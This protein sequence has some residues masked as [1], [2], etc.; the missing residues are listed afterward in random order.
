MLVTLGM[1][2]R[3]LNFIFFHFHSMT[4]T[5]Y[6]SKSQPLILT[7]TA[8][9]QDLISYFLVSTSTLLIYDYC[10]TLDLECKLLWSQPLKWF[11]VLY[12][13]QRYLPLIDTVVL[14]NIGIFSSSHSQTYCNDVLHFSIWLHIAGMGLSE[15]N[16]SLDS[17]LITLSYCPQSYSI[18]PNMGRI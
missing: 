16:V 12:L 6:A 17:I 9:Y 18:T 13:V 7:K 5:L 11:N 4:S 8:S 15:G 2:W 14:L 10:L 1:V 3:V